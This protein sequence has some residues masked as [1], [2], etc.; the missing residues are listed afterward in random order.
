MH[1]L[2]CCLLLLYIQKLCFITLPPRTILSRTFSTIL[3]DT[4]YIDS[5]STTIIV[6]LI[7]DRKCRLTVVERFQ[8]V[9]EVKRSKGQ[10][11]SSCRLIETRENSDQTDCEK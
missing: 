9:K 3:K 7:A 4:S 5:G 10:R 6:T 11:V 2:Y 1:I 8:R